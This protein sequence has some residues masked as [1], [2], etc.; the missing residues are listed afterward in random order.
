MLATLAI[1]EVPQEFIKSL[2]PRN[3]LRV[4]YFCLSEVIFPYSRPESK[5]WKSQCW[6]LPWK[7]KWKS[8][9]YKEGKTPTLVTSIFNSPCSKTHSNVV[10]LAHIVL[11]L[12]ALHKYKHQTQGGILIWGGILKSTEIKVKTSFCGNG[13]PEEMASLGRFCSE[14]PPAAIQ[15]MHSA[16][17]HLA[18]AQKMLPTQS[19]TTTRHGTAPFHSW[20]ALNPLTFL[21]FLFLFGHY[22]I[23]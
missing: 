7:G 10:G 22:S 12:R 19:S 3:C 1:W 4:L 23:F 17:L 21:F 18:E 9:Y 16:A 20:S 2:Q 15:G 6:S 14:V 13:I 5:A 11:G 8:K